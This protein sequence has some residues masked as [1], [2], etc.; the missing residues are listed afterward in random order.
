M[1]GDGDREGKST[2]ELGIPGLADLGQ[3]AVGS[4][5]VVYRARDV[6][7]GRTVAV[8]VL[9]R[10]RVDAA[11]ELALER[12]LAAMGRLSTHP[13]IIDLYGSGT[14]ADRHPYIVMPYYPRGNYADLVDDSGP[15]AW[16]EVVDFGIKIAGALHTAHARGFVHRDV[17]PA[18][19]FRGEFDRQ[20]ILADFGIASFAA[21]GVG[22]SFTVKVSTTPLYGAPEVLE[23][24]RPTARS[25]IYSLGASLFALTE[26]TPAFTD[27]S[28]EV[29]VHRVTAAKTP[30][31]LTASAPMALADLLTD[32][33]ARDP[34]RRPP[35]CLA[36]ARRLVEIQ[37]ANGI[38]PT[39]IVSD[40]VE[41]ETEV[42]GDR[43]PIQPTPPPNPAPE[44]ESEPRARLRI[45]PIGDVG[46]AVEPSSTRP[47][48]SMDRPTEP[49][50]DKPAR[51]RSGSVITGRARP[52]WHW[53]MLAAGGFLVAAV[54]YA[55]L[56]GSGSKPGEFIERS[57]DDR[58]AAA[59]RAAWADVGE[60]T[61][62]W[63]AH[64]SSWVTVVAFAPA[65]P[66]LATAGTDGAVR[67]WPLSGSNGPASEFDAGDWVVDA[68]WSP[69]GTQMAVAVTDG[70]VAV[71]SVD[72]GGP[73]RVGSGASSA[74][75]VAWDPGGTRLLEGYAGGRIVVRDLGGSEPAVLDGHDGDVLDLAWDPSGGRAV[76]S[77]KD[78]RVIVWDIE[79][80]APIA[81]VENPDRRWTRSVQ[82]VAATL[83]LTTD[84]DGTVT[85]RSVDADGTVEDLSSIDVGNSVLASDLRLDDGVLLA[86]G[87]AD[88]VVRIRDLV[89]GDEVV[90]LTPSGNGDATAVSWSST[91]RAL[92]VGR[93]DGTVQIWSLD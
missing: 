62:E 37:K 44:P 65:G 14:T 81:V 39:P 72:G 36:V 17:K 61:R 13:N 78:G 19:I 77:G 5:G 26:G 80:P 58:S 21:P 40:E 6:R 35:T 73:T 50:V 30:P 69:D 42:G 43:N 70:T 84:D 76:S 55:G 71:A 31:R 92:A 3:F 2:N 54:A 59:A 22:G 82:W 67:I 48:G 24:E 28:T 93:L 16:P 91:G 45:E 18:N 1:S 57:T 66:E 29:V 75:A 52:S 74:E 23:G 89:T 53:A 34:D 63:E 12:E 49:T 51:R 64:P 79:T 41:A 32:M 20:P 38:D 8:K 87:Y 25:D 4:S 60:P 56:T 83:V 90:E 15:L 7:H 27:P 88:G 86:V 46:A 85:L 33:M 47:V 11:T 10:G 9:H 68:A